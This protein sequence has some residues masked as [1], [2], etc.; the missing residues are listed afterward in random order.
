MHQNIREK[1]MGELP[2]VPMVYAGVLVEGAWGEDASTD[3][4]C[5][6][7]DVLA[8]AAAAGCGIAMDWVHGMFLLAASV[9]LRWARLAC[10]SSWVEFIL[11]FLRRALC[12]CSSLAVGS[13]LFERRRALSSCLSS[14][15]KLCR[16]A[17]WRSRDACRLWACMSAMMTCS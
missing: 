7:S 14:G 9:A 3:D 11:L 4:A 5:D 13:R 8:G 6:L 12:C 10:P 2:S 16:R 1:K 15:D 17:L